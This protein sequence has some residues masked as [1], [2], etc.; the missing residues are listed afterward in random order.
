MIAAI[1]LVLGFQSS[2]HLAAAYGVA[3]TT[4]M[5]ITTLLFYVV[6]RRRWHWPA[7]VALPAAAFFVVI[8]LA[9]FSANMLKVAHGGWFPILASAAILFLM[10]TW[11]KGRRVLRNCIGDVCLPLEDFLITA[12]DESIRRVPGTAIFM[13]GN[14]FA[15]PLALLHNLKHNK[16]LHETVAL[17]TV[18]TEEVPYLTSAKDRVEIEALDEGF[19]RVVVHFGFME[20]PDVPAALE[21]IRNSRLRFDPMR[22]TYFIGRETILATKKLGLS[23]WR[24][25]VFA[26]MTRNA[27]DVTSYFS[28]P[29]NAVVELGAR[30]EV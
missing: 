27:G 20:R 10:L 11:R 17:L 23:S 28:L 3:I 5:L 6:A 12:K 9:F 8:D 22:T 4:T 13:S 26:W 15:T 2:T 14:R 30:V 1:G 16:V 24:G 29:P 21:T 7:A 25:S 18:R 19:W